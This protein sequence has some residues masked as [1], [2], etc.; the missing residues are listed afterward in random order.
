MRCVEATSV[1]RSGVMK[2]FCMA[3]PA[4]TSSEAAIRSMLPG[5]G[6]RAITGGRASFS[7]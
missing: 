1:V 5:L 7:G 6:T 4:S 2:A 3:R